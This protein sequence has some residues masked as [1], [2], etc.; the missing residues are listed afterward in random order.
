MNHWMSRH[1]PAPCLE[2]VPADAARP[3]SA[4][5]G[6]AV[7]ADRKGGAHFLLI[8]TSRIPG[9]ESPLISQPDAPNYF[10]FAWRARSYL[11]GKAGHRVPRETVGLAVNPP[12]ARSQD[13]LHIHIECLR[14]DVLRALA[15]AS[16]H[17]ED[18]WTPVEI[19]GA[20]FE[21][22]RLSG[23]ELG[24]R[25][26]FEILARQPPDPRRS[27]ADYT[28]V[29]AGMQFREGPGFAL[30]AGTERAGELL[31]DSACVAAA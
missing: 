29:L 7:L 18:A 17:L 1:D 8:P 23:E 10:A 12:R 13:Q 22:R 16:G 15:D 27:P 9:I 3:A 21:A 24:E 26:P 4:D 28:L 25:N 14:S 5:G 6:Y 11:A 31:L 20:H 2:V 19:G 30:L